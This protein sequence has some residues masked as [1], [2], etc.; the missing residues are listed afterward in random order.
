MKSRIDKLE[1][2]IEIGSINVTYFKNDSRHRDNDLPAIIYISGTR[3][4]H[5]NGKRHRDNSKPSTIYSDGK[6]EWYENGNLIKR[7]FI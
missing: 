4:W 6:M 5:I 2:E 1:Y 3:S 7:N